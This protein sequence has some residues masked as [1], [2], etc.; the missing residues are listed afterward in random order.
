[1]SGVSVR[2]IRFA[3]HSVSTGTVL[4]TFKHPR[5]CLAV[6]EPVELSAVAPPDGKPPVDVLFVAFVPARAESEWNAL[7]ETWFAPATDPDTAE[8]DAAWRGGR[9]RWRPGFAAVLLRDAMPDEVLPALVE[10]AFFEGELRRLEAELDAREEPAADDVSRAYTI[11]RRVKAH[12]PRIT[13]SIEALAQMRLTLARLAPRLT[14]EPDG[15]RSRRLASRLLQR[16]RT[17]AR[18]E[19]LDTRLEACED[20]YEGA[21]DRIADHKGWHTGH[22]LEI[23]IIIILLLEVILLCVDL[24]LRGG[25]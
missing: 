4:R 10:F 14:E 24:L 13:G 12:W 19:A 25:E 3:A 16:A 7:T 9:I 11:N 20:L 17:P 1:M 22:V 23:I 21:T 15:S 6:E 5:L 18:A 2:R 8:I